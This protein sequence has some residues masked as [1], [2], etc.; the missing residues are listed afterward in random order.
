MP[1]K[2]IKMCLSWL[3]RIFICTR[4]LA[5]KLLIRRY[6]PNY[7]P[8]VNAPFTPHSWSTGVKSLPSV[9]TIIIA[10]HSS[11]YI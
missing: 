8:T 10:S 11:A 5:T 1:L 7:S 4:R 2:Q 9:L 3:P 6:P